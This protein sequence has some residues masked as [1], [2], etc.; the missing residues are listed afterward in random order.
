MYD[1]EKRYGSIIKALLKAPK[2]EKGLFTLREGPYSLIEALQKK[3]PITC[4]T[5]CKVHSV[6]GNTLH[7]SQGIVEG[8]HIV[9]AAPLHEVKRLY[10]HPFWK[11]IPTH[12]MHNVHM[13]FLEKVLP[14]D[15]YGYLTHAQENTPIL[16]G[17]F[18]S[19]MYPRNS[20]TSGEKIS[21]F[22]GENPGSALEDQELFSLAENALTSHVK[23]TK[24][25]VAKALIRGDDAGVIYGPNHEEIVD[26][27]IKNA[28]SNLTFLGNY[29]DGV[30]VDSSVKRAKLEAFKTL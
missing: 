26:K 23:I 14:Y 9:L 27:I 29:I 8:D 25:P 5:N 4:R 10:P 6:A 20:G 15:G 11:K 2:E 17:T 12:T 24:K 22:I 13:G 1:F 21:F 3:T 30:S 18:D 28:P 16:G 19:R 7:T